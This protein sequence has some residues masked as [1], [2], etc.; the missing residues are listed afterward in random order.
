M[1][2]KSHFNPKTISFS[3][4]ATAALFVAVIIYL[5]RTQVPSH[6]ADF[7]S[8]RSIKGQALIIDGDSIMISSVKIRLVGIDAPEL[9]QSCGTKKAQYPCGLEAKKYLEQLIGNQPVTCRWHK[10]DKYHR[11]LATCRTKKVSN[12]NATLVRNGWAVSYYNYPEEEKEARK[13]KKGI[14]Q[15]NFQKPRK[16][17]KAHPRTE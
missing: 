8:K 4:F 13:Q 10:R 11:I 14:W 16:W 12:I 7:I 1:K 2:K 5:K 15:S 9:Q 6:E 3:I 17:R